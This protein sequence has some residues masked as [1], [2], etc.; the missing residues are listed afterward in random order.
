MDP[1]Y[2]SFLHSR[3][4]PSLSLLLL[5][6]GKLCLSFLHCR[7]CKRYCRW[8]SLSCLSCLR[9]G[10]TSSLSCFSAPYFDSHS[11]SLSLLLVVLAPRKLCLSCLPVFVRGILDDYISCLLCSPKETLP[12]SPLLYLSTPTLSASLACRSRSKET[13]SLL[14][15][16]LTWPCL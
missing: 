14:T 3:S 8:F 12:L 15:L 7:V 16:F 10:N 11:L 4:S 1:L 2:L 13:M 5:L 6:V 9:R